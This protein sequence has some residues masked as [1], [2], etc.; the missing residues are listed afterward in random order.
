MATAM[1][2]LLK[3]Q[4]DAMKGSDMNSVHEATQTEL[5]TVAPLT[6]VPADVMTEAK[7]P[8]FTAPSAAEIVNL[9]SPGTQ[10]LYEHLGFVIEGWDGMSVPKKK[11]ALIDLLYPSGDKADT[12]T[13][14]SAKV[15]KEVAITENKTPQEV[16]PSDV[17]HSTA[18][19]IENLSDGA[20]IE[21]RIRKLLEDTEFNAFKIGGLLAVAKSKSLFGSHVNFKEYVENTYGIK[22]R[23]AMY[24][25]DI[26]T[27]LL[28][29]GVTWDQVKGIGWT[30]LK[31]LIGILTPENVEFW[32]TKAESMKTLQLQAEIESYKAKQNSPDASDLEDSTT[33]KMV[34]TMT[35]KVHADQKEV[36]EAALEK[37]KE[38]ANTEVNTV[39][40]EGIC[41]EYLGKG[42]VKSGVVAPDPVTVSM[43][44]Y[45]NQV[46]AKHGDSMDDALVEI[47]EA[48]EKVFP[49]VN[50]TVEPV[51]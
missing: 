12:A 27:G 11:K 26:Y 38:F 15:T 13:V 6:I 47:F 16:L 48:F 37:A 1:K 41:L 7:A 35:F 2:L 25:V 33:V 46:A 24:W 22:Y 39:A 32:V 5:T 23:K 21:E 49:N 3:K 36:I 29:S 31:E 34:S 10:A 4:E 14:I 9:K 8:T 20:V 17:I 42:H 51:A 28:S 30:K 50:V 40:L 18:H 19:E 45:F 44:E 43:V